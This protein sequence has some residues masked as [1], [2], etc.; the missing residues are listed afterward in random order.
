M[1]SVGSDLTLGLESNSHLDATSSAL[2]GMPPL[3]VPT[4]HGHPTTV[5]QRLTKSALNHRASASFSDDPAG[6]AGAA[7]PALR[8]CLRRVCLAGTPLGSRRSTCRI[9]ARLST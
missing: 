5:R 6:V 4:V 1:S 8:S 3:D 7:A 2:A 9:R